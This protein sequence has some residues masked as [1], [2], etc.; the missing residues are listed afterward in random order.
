MELTFK[1]GAPENFDR[2]AK[3]T[4]L[5]MLKKQGQ[6]EKPSMRAINSCPV[7]CMVYSDEEVIGIGAIKQLY[8]INF[9][10][11]GLKQLKR[12]F[13]SE[14]GY[15]FVNDQAKNGSFRGLGI[16]KTISRLLLRETGEQN[17]FATTEI[18]KKN[19]MLWILESLGFKQYG[20][21]YKG[22]KTGKRIGTMLRFQEE[23]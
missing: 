6:N 3:N 12:D 11:S 23:E 2:K 13:E 4:F 17:V 15:L 8:R 18:N 14:I 5:N 21:S 1:I 20:K 7:L 19:P 22:K 9:N 16:G 10:Y